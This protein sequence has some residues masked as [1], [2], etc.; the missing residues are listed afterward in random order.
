MPTVDNLPV[1]W[2]RVM[3]MNPNIS[4]NIKSLRNAKKLTQSELAE[5]VGVT[6]ATISA[7]EVGTRMPS[8]DVL[9]KLAQVFRVSTDN[10]L[11]VSNKFVLD[12]SQLSAHQRNTVQEIISL[13]ELKNKTAGTK[14]SNGVI[15]Q[16]N[17]FDVEEYKKQNG[18]K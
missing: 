10:L 12:V 2:L 9:I 3:Q 13:Y 15:S 6:N 1:K 18:I 4:D 16:T 8:F 17:E 7:Y 14:E 5:R 11:G